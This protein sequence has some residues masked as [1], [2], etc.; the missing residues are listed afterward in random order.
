MYVTHW[1]NC[2]PR[3]AIADTT[4]LVRPNSVSAAYNVLISVLNWNGDAVG[5]PK[6][7]PH[8]GS[9][10]GDRRGVDQ[11]IIC[12]RGEIPPHSKLPPASPYNQADPGITRITVKAE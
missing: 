2:G 7:E 11:A 1:I 8:D 9:G 10:G 3:Q 5:A 4:T 6:L 12:S